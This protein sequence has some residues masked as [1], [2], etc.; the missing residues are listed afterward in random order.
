M[1]REGFDFEYGGEP[2]DGD[3]SL[4]D[5]LPSMHSYTPDWVVDIGGGS[6]MGLTIDDGCLLPLVRDQFGFWNA[7]TH[8]P[9]ALARRMGEIAEAGRP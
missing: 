8:V 4:G 3:P 5:G 6:E 7:A 9:F 1:A 2:N